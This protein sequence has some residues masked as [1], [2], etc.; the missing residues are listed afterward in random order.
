MG[1]SGASQFSILPLIIDRACGVVDDGHTLFKP[2][3]TACLFLTISIVLENFWKWCASYVVSLA[4]LWCSSRERSTAAS[5]EGAFQRS[6]YK[7]LGR[8][9]GDGRVWVVEVGI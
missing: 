4:V 3:S 1:T 9:R 8:G 2:K 6:Q 7:L 5:R